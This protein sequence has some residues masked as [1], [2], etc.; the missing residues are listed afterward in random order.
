MSL[1][2]PEQIS[3]YEADAYVI[4]RGLFSTEE[5]QLLRATANR[6]K[7]MDKA[8]PTMDDGRGNEVRRLMEPSRRR[9][10]M[11]CSPAVGV[12]EAYRSTTE[13]IG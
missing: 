11:L 1:L 4:A 5:P 2:S 10:Y 6:D 8:S 7:V 12:E 3:S 13:M 9:E